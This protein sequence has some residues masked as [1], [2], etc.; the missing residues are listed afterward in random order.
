[1]GFEADLANYIAQKLGK[2]ANFIPMTV[3]TRDQQLKNGYIDMVVGTYSITDAR[4]EDGIVFAGPYIRTDQGILTLKTNTEI[5]SVD[6]LAGQTVCVTAKSTS[7]Q[8]INDL[9]ATVKLL[10]T[11]RDTLDTCIADMRNPSMNVAAVTTDTVILQGYAR[12]DTSIRYVP[13]LV[14][15][16]AYEKYGVGLSAKN[17]ELCK[18]TATIVKDFLNTQW[19]STFSA[20]IQSDANSTAQN[21]KPDPSSIDTESCRTN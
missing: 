4:I 13:R 6:D 1:M 7:E 20:N 16:G 21:L 11:Q 5:M 8:K 15:P 17:I 19:N 10:V 3:G 2:H 18:Q 14:I 12:Q 9:K